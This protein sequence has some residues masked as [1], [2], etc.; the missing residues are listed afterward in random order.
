[1]EQTLPDIQGKVCSS[2]FWENFPVSDIDGEKLYMAPLI[3]IARICNICPTFR[4]SA[5]KV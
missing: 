3:E 5:F 1:M 2:L 4:N